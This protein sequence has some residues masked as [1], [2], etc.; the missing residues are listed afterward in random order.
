MTVSVLKYFGDSDDTAEHI[1]IRVRRVGGREMVEAAAGTNAFVRAKNETVAYARPN[2]TVFAYYTDGS[3]VKAPKPMALPTWKAIPTSAGKTFEWEGLVVE[4]KTET[5]S[6]RLQNVK[7]TEVDFVEIAEFDL[8]DVSQGDRDLLKPGGIFRWVVGLEAR[9]GT[10]QKY[11]RIVFRRLP[12]WTQRSL[13]QADQS[14]KDM[15][16]EIQWAENDSACGR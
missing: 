11:S 12:A 14:L 8:S 2:S 5:F 15:M 16:S 10:R 7:G 13:K 6:A 4:V 3:S 9:S 1:S